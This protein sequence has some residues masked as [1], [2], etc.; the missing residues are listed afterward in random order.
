MRNT[1]FALIAAAALATAAHAQTPAPAPAPPAAYGPALSYAQAKAALAAAEAEARKNNWTMAISVVEPTGD[2]VA[3][4]KLDGTQYGS[5]EVATRKA[6]S[7]ALFKRPSK[8]FADQ[9]AS[10][11]MTGMILP[12]AFPVQGGVPIIVGGKIVGAI[13]ASGGTGAQDE[14][15]S[16][17]GAA[18]VK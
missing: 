17:A 5:I 15:V 4:G 18:A 2:M 8:V 7:A 10:G 12:G 6:K 16:L 9:L 11:T 1:V 13:G 14:Q 3:F